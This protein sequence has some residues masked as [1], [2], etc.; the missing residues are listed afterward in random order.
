MLTMLKDRVMAGV[1]IGLLANVIK[2]S[3]NYLGFLLNF[4]PVVF[5][6]M[7]AAQ[8][9]A[10]EDLFRP[11]AYLIGAAADLA[12]TALLGAA[13]V[14]VIRFIGEEYLYIKGLGFGLTVWAILFGSFFTARIQEK[15]PPEPSA[16]LVTLVAHSIFG[17]SLA[18]F[19]EKLWL[20]KQ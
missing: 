9:L 17:L 1:L 11:A 14:Y 2:L 10:R 16:I 19:T 6:Q 4:T 15:I 7:V 18:F 5:W 20:E 8:F 13:F 12:M 3:V